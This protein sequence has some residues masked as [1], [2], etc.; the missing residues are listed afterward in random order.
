MAGLSDNIVV[1]RMKEWLGCH[2]R[3]RPEARCELRLD[4]RRLALTACTSLLLTLSIPSPAPRPQAA[5]P[6]LYQVRP[7]VNIPIHESTSERP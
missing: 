1:S 2:F 4:K 5:S 3:L 7:T 6:A